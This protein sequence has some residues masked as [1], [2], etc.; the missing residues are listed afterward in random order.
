MRIAFYAPRASYL[1]PGFSGDVVL[2]DSLLT[3]LRERGHEVKIVSRL[4]V[5]DFWRGRVSVRRLITEAIAVHKEMKRF[6]ADVWLVF[7]PSVT[8]P[9]LFGW[10]QHPK[11]Y[12]LWQA[13]TGNP[14]RLPRRWRWLFSFS[15]RRSFGR[16]DKVAVYRP[17]SAVRLRS[18]GVA[19]E[20]LSLLPPAVKAWDGMPSREEAR[21]RLG[22][23]QDAPVILC[24]SRFTKRRKD[25]RPGEGY[26]LSLAMVPVASELKTGLPSSNPTDAFGLSDQWR[27]SDHSMRRATSSLILIC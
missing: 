8:Y 21:R 10:W 15:H 11:R 23:P 24:V 13:D 25:G 16:A 20:R 12:V 18:F 9:D 1:G 26:S 22:L 2:L 17:R 7:G 4:D 6:S 5:Q 3:G 19:V 14:E 27:I